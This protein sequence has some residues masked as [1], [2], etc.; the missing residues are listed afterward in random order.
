MENLP[1]ENL[2]KETKITLATELLKSQTF[3]NFLAKKFSGLKRYGGEGAESMMA[4]F[5]EFFRLSAQGILIT[6]IYY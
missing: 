3:D 1:H 5:Y 4:F 6:G 2:N